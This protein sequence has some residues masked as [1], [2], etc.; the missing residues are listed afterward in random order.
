MTVR[1]LM[2]EATTRGTVSVFDGVDLVAGKDLAHE[3][4]SWGL[5]DPLRYKKIHTDSFYLC[6]AGDITEV[7]EEAL[8]GFLSER[9]G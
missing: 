8:Q 6:E 7:D 5:D 1:E 9:K 3:Q 4:E 2:E